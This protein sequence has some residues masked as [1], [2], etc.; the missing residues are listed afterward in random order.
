MTVVGCGDAFG[1]GGRLQTCYHIDLGAERFLIDCGATAL[2]GLERHGLEP[3]RVGTILISHLHGDHFAGL[4]WW[5]LHAIHVAKRR[6]PL[7]VI[8]PTGLSERFRAAA[9]VLFPGSLAAPPPFQL[10]LAE[11]RAGQR[12]A[13]AG[14][15]AWVEAFDVIHPSGAPSH[16]LR[17]EAGGKTVAFS[18]DTEWD[19][20]LIDCGR[21]ADLML[22]E[23][24]GL[25]EGV[26]YHMNWRRLSKELPRFGMKRMVLT[27]MSRPM[28]DGGASAIADT[29]GVCL[30]EDGMVIDI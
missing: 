19:D 21:N 28:L 8:G 17:V 23:C 11:Q 6:H 14:G 29:P 10:V 25:D 9:E 22:C 30:A 2:I 1:S 16:A 15:Q 20:A 18:G 24:Y 3:D 26:R 12:L 4:V 27:H 13:F 5:Y 7:T